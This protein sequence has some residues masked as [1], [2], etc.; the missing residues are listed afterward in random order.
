MNLKV[1]FNNII[2]ILFSIFLLFLVYCLF[3]RKELLFIQKEKEYFKEKY[4]NK[5]NL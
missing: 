3:N 1:N 2:I 5:N 4:E